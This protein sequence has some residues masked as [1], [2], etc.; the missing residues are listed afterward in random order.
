[1]GEILYLDFY[2]NWKE[3]EA[4]MD[5][6]ELLFRAR[7]AHTSVPAI[8]AGLDYVDDAACWVLAFPGLDGAKGLVPATEAGMN[9]RDMKNF[10]GAKMF[11]KVK[12]IDRENH[13][14]ACS[15]KEAFAEAVKRLRNGAVYAA[16]VVCVGSGGTLFALADDALVEITKERARKFLSLPIYRQYFPGQRIDVKILSAEDYKASGE[17]VRPD[18]WSMADF[19]RGQFV[20]ALVNNLKN[21][22]AFLEPELCPGIIGIA[23][24]PLEGSLVRG[25]RVV[26]VVASFDREKKKLRFRL[27]REAMQ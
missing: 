26:A 15:A 12:G 19:K 25:T 10:V 14:A 7:I 17:V 18:P 11:V 24:A 16:S 4:F 2:R 21:D 3:G 20:S 6:M 22:I 5:A 8:V 9:E 1:M 27:V 13:L 23:P